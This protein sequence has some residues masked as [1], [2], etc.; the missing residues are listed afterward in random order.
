MIERKPNGR[1][2]YS[3]SADILNSKNLIYELR[4]SVTKIRAFYVGEELVSLK[5]NYLNRKLKPYPEHWGYIRL[6]QILSEKFSIEKE[7]NYVR[8]N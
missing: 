1:V 2:L 7:R 8:L 4:N 3:Y 5:A 6:L